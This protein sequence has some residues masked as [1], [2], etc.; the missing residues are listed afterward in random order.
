MSPQVWEWWS[1]LNCTP[2]SSEA[3][4]GLCLSWLMHFT[5][6]G[7]EGGNSSFGQN[8]H[9]IGAF[10]SSLE[11]PLKLIA[12]IQRG[13]EILELAVAHH[14]FPSEQVTRGSL[15]CILT[16][17]TACWGRA[18]KQ[19]LWW[20]PSQ[21]GPSWAALSAVWQEQSGLAE[22]G[23]ASSLCRAPALHTVLPRKKWRLSLAE[24]LFCRRS[25]Q[26]S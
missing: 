4:V 11:K 24:A 26:G 21:N 5:P 7:T 20:R 3:A 15:L 9:E 19:G 2:I 22:T 10:S 6:P 23:T 13:H 12:S 18:G 14:P 16:H 8:P 1:L 17:T 25:V